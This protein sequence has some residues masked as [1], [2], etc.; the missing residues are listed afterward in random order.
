MMKKK[1]IVLIDQ[2][3]LMLEIVEAILSETSDILLQKKINSWGKGMQYLKKEQPDILLIDAFQYRDSLEILS[4]LKNEFPEMKMI[5]FTFC[6]DKSLIVRALNTGIEGYVAKDSDYEHIIRSIEAVYRGEDYFFP[7][8]SDLMMEDMKYVQQ[9]LYHS[10]RIQDL[11][12]RQ[13]EVMSLIA[14]GYSN[15]QIAEELNISDKT[16]KNH[17][18][19]LLRKMNF[20][21]RTQAAVFF[22]NHEM[23]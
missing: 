6:K 21:D 16:V 17:V 13:R 1:S 19:A 3:K 11:T 15:L 23:N 5:L 7:P 20:N 18:S 14:K 4:F 22:L 8:V 9:A 10:K 2:Q 12:K